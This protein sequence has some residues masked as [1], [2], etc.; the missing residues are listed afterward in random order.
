M[1]NIFDDELKEINEEFSLD[2]IFPLK[3]HSEDYHK[4]NINNFTFEGDDDC[5]DYELTHPEECKGK[6][7]CSVQEIL[8]TEG[9]SEIQHFLDDNNGNNKNIK[10][11]NGDYKIEY[12]EQFDNYNNEWESW[13]RIT[14]RLPDAQNT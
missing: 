12:K 7:F 6:D 9:V 14:E 10:I 13:V 3:Y 4:I 5:V 8:S 1:V 11:P 2:D